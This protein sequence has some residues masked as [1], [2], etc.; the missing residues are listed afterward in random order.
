M[1]ENHRQTNIEFVT[2]IMEYSK[3]GGMA[4]LFVIDALDKH[5]HAVANAPPEAFAKSAHFIS[6][7]AWQG[8]A[9]E[10]A[11]KLKNRHLK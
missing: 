6:T 2:E 9:R 7:E 11:G 3:Y 1:E 10:I 4:Q 5:S 8:V